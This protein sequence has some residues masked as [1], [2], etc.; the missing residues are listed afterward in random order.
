M[1]AKALRFLQEFS[2]FSNISQTNSPTAR[3][4]IEV[5]ELIDPP[6]HRAAKRLQHKK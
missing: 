5:N 3:K 4:G 1:K 2:D 6:L